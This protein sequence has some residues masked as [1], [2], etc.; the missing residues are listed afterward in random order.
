MGKFKCT[1]ATAV[2]VL[3][4]AST[5]LSTG[6]SAVDNNTS[7]VNNKTLKPVLSNTVNNNTDNS[8]V[9]LVEPTTDSPVVA[10][11]EP[12]TALPTEAPSELPTVAP[13]SVPTE[14]ST[15]IPTELPTSL[16]TEQPTVKPTEKPTEVPTIPLVTNFKY[17]DAKTNS[18]S[19]KWDYIEN[20][21]GYILYRMDSTTNSKYIYH[22]QF[23]SNST[24]SYTDLFVTPARKY[25]YQIRAYR[26][27]NNKAV[28]SQPTTLKIG[29]CPTPLTGLEFKN[30]TSTSIE[31]KWNKVS[32]A[33]G[34]TVYR[35]DYTTDGKYKKLAD[36]SDKYTSLRNNG[37]ETGRQYFY[38]IVAYKDVNGLKLEG[39]E[40]IIKTAT[41]PA[42]VTNLKVKSQSTSNINIGWDR[43][44]RAT[45]YVIYRM[46]SSTNG[47]YK[48]YK[49]VNGNNNITFNDTGLKAGRC[50]YYRVRAY[51]A[52]NGKNYYGGYP[53]LKT[54]TATVV[55]QF[56]L[57]TGNNTIT[58]SWSAV[59]G[60]EG[61]AFYLA[62]SKTSHYYLQGHTT[63]TSYTSKTLKEGRT[64]Y[65]RVCA[66]NLVN[67]KKIYS[68]FQTKSLT[69]KKNNLVAG[70]DVGDTY[71][72]IDIDQ[73]RMWYYKDGNLMV[74]TN[75]VTGY[76]G[77]H[78][79]P[80]G[81]YNVIQLRSP[82]RLVGPTWDVWVNYWIGVT[83]DGVGIH[84]STWRT[85]GYG[86]NIYTYDGSHGCVNTPYNNV[87]IIYDNCKLGTPV[88]IH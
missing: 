13:T 73:Q 29:T 8:N 53:T 60:A 86:G 57:T 37:L 42:T 74:S 83:W 19:L 62:E 64:Y 66:Y 51:R 67:G 38:K 61:Y 27:K 7:F 34:Y 31:F 5:L 49:V 43:V 30:N 22:T 23:K 68:S 72:E 6:A 79:T 2:A 45:G 82:S 14:K 50:Y 15:E 84:D 1:L 77:V 78:D 9:P 26:V 3:T 46:D 63:S 39:K 28:Y 4:M 80:K 21:D 54:G 56:T 48:L 10:P 44:P 17:T 32:G 87:K 12:T 70:Y 65:V 52:I 75:V 55:P 20:V 47:K 16:P 69:C 40:A 81:L 88:V 58:A 11:T 36:L 33:S 76:K 24:T 41:L 85:S 25:Y 59:S 18:I 35:V 71:I